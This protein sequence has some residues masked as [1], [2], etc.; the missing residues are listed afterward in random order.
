MNLSFVVFIVFV[1]V[2]VVFVEAKKKQKIK[3]STF[4]ALI[5]SPSN[6]IIE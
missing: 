5:V 3:H 1:I 2:I 4:Y 6:S